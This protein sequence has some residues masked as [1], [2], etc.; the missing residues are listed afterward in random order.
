MATLYESNM[1]KHAPSQPKYA[2]CAIIERK[3]GCFGEHKWKNNF[4]FHEI[5]YHFHVYELMFACK[6]KYNHWSIQSPFFRRSAMIIK[7]I[8]TDPN[9]SWIFPSNKSVQMG[10]LIGGG[11]ITKTTWTLSMT[12]GCFEY[13]FLGYNSLLGTICLPIWK[14]VQAFFYAD[15][16]GCGCR[17]GP[18]R[19]I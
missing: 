13:R 3:N 8:S 18:K 16:S 12:S 9:R 1:C 10:L 4:F 19:L 15:P 17:V 7:M 5:L 2:R 6:S 14:S 11:R